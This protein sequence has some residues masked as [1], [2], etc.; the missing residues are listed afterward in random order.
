ML[1]SPK[2]TRNI[3]TKIVILNHLSIYRCQA[4][5]CQAKHYKC[6]A[7]IE[8]VSLNKGDKLSSLRE[9]TFQSSVL[10]QVP[11]KQGE[12]EGNGGG[13]FQ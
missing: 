6:Q 8:N 5:H 7:N 1:K 11:E 4:K 10:G 2:T 9:I 12:K 13:K 3:K